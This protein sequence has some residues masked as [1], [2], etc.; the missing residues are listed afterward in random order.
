MGAGR[1]GE[2]CPRPRRRG[3]AL[4]G[5]NVPVID[6]IQELV[7]TEL[8]VSEWLEITQD[9]INAF[10]D[11]TDDHQWIHVDTDRAAAG[12]FGSTIAHGFLTLSMIVSMTA[13]VALPVSEPKMGINYG[14]D[15]VRFIA[16]V[17]VGSRIR[18]RVEMMEATEVPG[19]IQI[20]RKVTT[21]V[22]GSDKPAMVAETLSRLIY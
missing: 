22:E 19:G 21:E 8:G 5:H 10:A 1:G 15:R 12:P 16:P 6:Q 14:L 13:E 11:A 7:G 4:I 18:A 9:R 17:P 2:G 3:K 20:K